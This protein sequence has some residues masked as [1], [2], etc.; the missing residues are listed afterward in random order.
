MGTTWEEANKQ[1]NKQKKVHGL[2]YSL[3]A[4]NLKIDIFL[5]L[6]TKCGN[7]LVKHSKFNKTKIKMQ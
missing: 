5:N 7:R 1:T 4:I 6:D 2:E 3:Q